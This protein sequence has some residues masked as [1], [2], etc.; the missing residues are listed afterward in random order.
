MI[1]LGTNTITVE[2]FKRNIEERYMFSH[3]KVDESSFTIT[4]Y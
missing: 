4:I 2:L 1:C 3:A